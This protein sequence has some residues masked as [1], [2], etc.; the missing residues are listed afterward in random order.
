LLHHVE[1]IRL[2][3]VKHGF[4]SDPEVYGWCFIHKNTFG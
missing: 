1:Y 4:V 3:P 2:N